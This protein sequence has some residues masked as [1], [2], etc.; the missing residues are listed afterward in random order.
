[1][2]CGWTCAGGDAACYV[3]PAPDPV[4]PFLVAPPN[5][6]PVA[7]PLTSC[8]DVCTENACDGIRVGVEE[9][10][11]GNCVDGDGCTMGQTIEFGWE[12]SGGAPFPSCSRDYCNE[13]CGDGF[14]M[15]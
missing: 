11:D 6:P 14:N 12:C 10:D 1:M 3:A 9:C 2:E 13:I 4:P 15:G 8:N 5:Y 7:G